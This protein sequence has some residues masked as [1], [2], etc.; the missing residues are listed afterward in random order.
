[1]PPD[2]P[3]QQNSRVVSQH[4][5]SGIDNLDQRP[6]YDDIAEY[7][8][9]IYADWE[10]SMHRH[11]AAISAMLGS[12]APSS[13]RILDASAGIGTQAL[14]LA[15]A[16][17]EVVARDLSA[18]SILRLERE[19]KTRGLSIDVGTADMRDIGRSV[20]G[21]FD[22]IVAFDDS[23]PHLLTDAE[24]EAS[25]A[26][27][28]KL[29]APGGRVLISVRDYSLVNREPSSFHDYGE[30][31]RDGGRFRLGQEWLWRS[32][33]HYRTTMVIEELVAGA[34][35]AVV[36]TDAEYYAVSVEGLL[37]LMRKAHLIPHL[38]EDV[39]FFQPVLRAGAG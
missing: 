31:T 32:P 30:R 8:D 34:W 14:P 24:I 4:L 25:F 33:S 22:A 10:G 21:F 20:T 26:G 1:L 9:L 27:F 2:S 3:R 6:F 5:Q 15:A 23:I 36:R 19:A 38:V 16:G 12:P 13:C 37:E 29:L 28:S 17:Y 7:Y 35:T 18:K 39:P 11:A